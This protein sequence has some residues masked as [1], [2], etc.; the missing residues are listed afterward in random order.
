MFLACSRVIYY[1]FLTYNSFLLLIACRYALAP[2]A[3]LALRSTGT[4]CPRSNLYPWGLCTWVLRGAQSDRAPLPPTSG[5]RLT[6]SLCWLV[7]FLVSLSLLSQRTF[8]NHHPHQLLATWI[9]AP[10]SALGKNSNR[11]REVWR[12]CLWQANVMYISWKFLCQYSYW[13]LSKMAK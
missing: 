13:V 1:V 10:E 8:W 9:F 2:G 4:E 11:G 7:S 3:C 5:E 6:N 12:D